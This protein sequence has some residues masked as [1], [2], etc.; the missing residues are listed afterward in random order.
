LLGGLVTAVAVVV[1]LYL[2]IPGEHH[3]NT[4]MRLGAPV[5]LA[6]VLLF[7]APLLQR[8]VLSARRSEFVLDEDLN[9]VLLG[10]AI[11]LIGGLMTG[12]TLAV[13]LI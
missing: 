3:A 11:G 9:A 2:G 5:A 4:A 12:A 10:R 7:P 6:S 13:E 1:M 8:T